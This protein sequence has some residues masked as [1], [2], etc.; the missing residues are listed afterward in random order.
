VKEALPPPFTG[1]C[2]TTTMLEAR[3]DDATTSVFRPK[4]CHRSPFQLTS[5]TGNLHLCNAPLV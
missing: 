1:H 5:G 3:E 4:V 2:A